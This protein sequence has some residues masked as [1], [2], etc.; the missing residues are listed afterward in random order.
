MTH[1]STRPRLGEGDDLNFP[2]RLR[3]ADGHR[4]PPLLLCSR[5]DDPQ[6]ASKRSVSMRTMFGIFIVAIA[7]V[8]ACRRVHEPI[9]WAYAI[10]P[11]APAGAAAPARRHQRE[12]SG[13]QQRRVH[14]RANLRSLWPGR[15]VSGRPSAH[16]RRGGAWQETRRVG[17]RLMPLSQRQGPPGKCRRRGLPVAYF[18]QTMNDF[19][20][21]FARAPSLAKTTPIS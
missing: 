19:R 12:T 9:P 13:R 1:L 11:A 15:L 16:A 2:L 21:A 5:V 14:P 3:V 17:L 18:I 7:A 4:Q 10:P 6:L 20:T 8:L